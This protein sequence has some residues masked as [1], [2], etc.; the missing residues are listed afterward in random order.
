MSL[1]VREQEKLMACL[2]VLFVVILTASKVTSFRCSNQQLPASGDDDFQVVTTV[3]YCLVDDCTIKRFDTGEN[4]DVAYTTDGLIV[5]TPT[6]GH[7]SE[8]IAKQENELPCSNPDL[9]FDYQLRHIVEIV[10]FSLTFVVS[11]YIIAVHAMFKELRN[12][13]GK[14]LILYNVAVLGMCISYFGILLT[15]LQPLLDSLAFCY[16]STIGLIV[17]SVSIEALATCILSHIATTMR[18]SYKRRSQMPKDTSQ[19]HFNFYVIYTVG[20]T[21][22]DVFLTICFDVATGNYKDA[23][24]PNGQCVTFEVGAYSTLQITF[25]VNGIHKIVQLVR[26]ITYLYYTYKIIKEISNDGASSDLNP[27]LHKLAVAMGAFIGLAYFWF[28]LTAIFGLAMVVI[29]FTQALFLMQQSA[30]MAIFLC[31]KK[32]HRLHGECFSK[33]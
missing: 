17:S 6:D 20:I 22:L 10:E 14:L 25:L 19:R 28:T 29:P 32:V 18:H 21:L 2:T 3:Q 1:L 8:V 7:T 30:V 33:E 16:I 12:L 11:G 24:L 4:L 9:T 15:P 27:Y 5:T 23:V 31:S 13:L 26:L